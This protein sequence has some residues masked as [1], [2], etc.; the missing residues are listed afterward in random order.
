ATHATPTELEATACVG[1]Y[2]H[3]VLHER[4]F[5]RLKTRRLN[6]QPVFLRNEQRM[7]GL[8]WLLVLALR[9]LTLTEF[10]VRRA[11]KQTK[12][13]LIGLNPAAPSQVTQHPTVDRLLATFHP[14]HLTVIDIQGQCL[15][16]VTQL[17]PTQHQI[18]A[19]LNLPDDL[20]SHLAL[21]PP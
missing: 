13:E 16:Y 5:S 6:I 1:L 3:Q 12:A 19:L 7:V 15:R 14:L 9:I 4:T 11:L 17:T 10:R 20:Y 8:T 2:R 18:L 21:P